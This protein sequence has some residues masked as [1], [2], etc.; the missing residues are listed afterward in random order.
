M[1]YNQ[2]QSEYKENRERRTLSNTGALIIS[3]I[4]TVLMV[5]CAASLRSD[6]E[7]ALLGIFAP[8]L[9]CA[10]VTLLAILL[11]HSRTSLFFSCGICSV[12]CV[13]VLLAD[14]YRAL[15]CLL[16]AFCAYLFYA[17]T[18]KKHFT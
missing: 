7:N 8:A 13:F 6:G 14:A 11:I 15:L 3:V 10:A 1:N 9:Y 4:A 16:C 17:L 5:A 18:R 12:V 2:H